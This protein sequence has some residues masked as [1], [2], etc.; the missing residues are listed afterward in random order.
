M[1]TITAIS[2]IVQYFRRLHVNYDV[3]VG[4]LHNEMNFCCRPILR[5][6]GVQ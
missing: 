5:Y 6:I 1:P 3:V 2:D 4:L